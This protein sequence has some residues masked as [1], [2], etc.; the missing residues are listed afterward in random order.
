MKRKREWKSKGYIG[1][2]KHIKR[3]EGQGDGNVEG[4]IMKLWRKEKKMTSDK[5]HSTSPWIFM[6]TSWHKIIKT[7]FSSSNGIAFVIIITIFLQSKNDKDNLK[8]KTL[9]RCKINVLYLATNLGTGQNLHEENLSAGMLQGIR[10]GRVFDGSLLTSSGNQGKWLCISLSEE[11]LPSH[12]RICA[13]MHSFC[14]S[15]FATQTA[16]VPMLKRH[17]QS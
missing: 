1:R 12:H 16:A 10:P 6:A 14:F 15:L 7:I 2:G 8:W 13:E 5:S 17:V 4:L 3:Q 9:T 11:W